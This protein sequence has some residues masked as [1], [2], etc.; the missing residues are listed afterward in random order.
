MRALPPPR[1]ALHRAS[2]NCRAPLPAPRCT[3][4]ESRYLTAAN[5]YWT[6]AGRAMGQ[7]DISPYVSWAAQYPAAVA[8]LLG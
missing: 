1:R 7:R 8:N 2:L 3:P 5:T 4:G 6:A